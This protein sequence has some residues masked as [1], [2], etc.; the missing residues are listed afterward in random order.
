MTRSHRA[1][2]P[3]RGDPSPA[4][5]PAS[6]AET[7]LLNGL[8]H[9]RVEIVNPAPNANHAET[10]IPGRARSPQLSGAAALCQAAADTSPAHPFTQARLVVRPPPQ[11][12]PN[13]FDTIARATRQ[14]N[15]GE[16]LRS[17]PAG[18]SPNENISM[19]TLDLFRHELTVSLYPIRGV[20]RRLGYHRADEARFTRR[21][22][23]S[24]F[25]Q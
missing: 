19:S 4:T 22:F 10:V 20:C 3:P 21:A 16:P 5:R 6:R 7:Q 18:V 25:P 14:S 9:G 23:C 12:N 17:T 2:P 24:G 1:D 11:P 13:L 8:G 15:A